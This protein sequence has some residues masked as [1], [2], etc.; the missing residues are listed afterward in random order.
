MDTDKLLCKNVIKFFSEIN[1]IPRGSGNEK[2]ISDFLVKFAKERGLEVIQDEALN[3]LIRKPAYPGFE[4]GSP[5]IL[6]GHMDMVCEK[7]A[8]KEH[9]F[10]ND[11]IDLIFDGDYIKADRTTLGADDGVAVAMAMAVLDSDIIPHPPL[12]VLITT[13]EEVGMFGARAFDTDLLRGRILINIDSEVEGVFMAGCA[14]G[15]RAV[16]TLPVSLKK[17]EGKLAF[18]LIV[19]GLKG[20]HS[21]VDINK[22]RANANKLLARALKHIKTRM[23]IEAGDLFG[24]SKDNAIPREAQAVITASDKAAV[25]KAV[26]ILNNEL[27]AEYSAAD[28]NVKVVLEET[29]VPEAVFDEESLNRVIGALLLIPCGIINMSGNIPGL[30]ETSNNI[31][32]VRTKGDK[33]ILSGSLRSA[34]ETRKDF[35]ESVI[36]SAARLAGGTAEFSGDYPV[37]EFKEESVI[38]PLIAEVYERLYGK[39]AVADIIH[40][41]LECGLL[42]GKCPDLDMISMGP[43]IFDIHTPDERLSIS[44]TERTYKLLTE[45]LNVL[46]SMQ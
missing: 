21:G 31:G 17:P 22:E 27:S 26:Y 15:A 25:E 20:G 43:D 35:V 40:A 23:P 10:L 39:K 45:V 5:V 12:E 14:G 24:G 13:D 9:D 2:G 38:R 41:G 16:V 8:G 6:Q 37:W 42:E 44:S 46:A 32:S 18:K 30:P 28:P 4:K 19:T 7:N 29:S 1:R 33:V 36:D 3:V 34:V 11:P